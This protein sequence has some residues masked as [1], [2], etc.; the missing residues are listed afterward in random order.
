MS[1]KKSQSPA[2]NPFKEA[3]EATP[4]V[5]SC[6]Q[7]GLQ[8][9]GPHS[10]KIDLHDNRECNGSLEIDE[11]VRTTYPNSNRWDY[12]FAYKSIAYFVEVHSA[13]SNEV[14]VVLAKLQWLKDWLNEKAPKIGRLKAKQPYYWIQ[15][16]RFSIPKTSRQYRLAAKNGIMP[17]SKLT[18]K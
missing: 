18:L 7:P 11:C 12:V 4:E 10:N 5:K 15:S 14:S 13:E 1:K 17:I 2:A 9:L 8:A 6:Y 3:V 16:G